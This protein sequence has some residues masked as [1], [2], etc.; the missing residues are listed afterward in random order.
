MKSI[1][2]ILLGIL[3]IPFHISAQTPEKNDP[4][5]QTILDKL[6]KATKSYNSIKATFTF[7]LENKKENNSESQDGGLLLKGNKYKLEIAG[8]E[9]ICNGS[10]LWTYIKDAEEVQINEPE[11]EEGSI[12][13]ANIF[14][15]YESGFK[16]RFHSEEEYEG[17][18]CQIVN[19]Y[20][21]DANEKPY[22][23]IRLFIDK[24]KNQL[25]SIKIMGKEGDNYYYTINS[26]A[27][28]LELTDADFEFDPS[29]HPN[30]EVVDL[31]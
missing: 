6:S 27:T 19:L 7:T 30:V 14:T 8:Q 31:R 16:F 3:I 18:T 25:A 24:A 23:T 29:K 9:I 17:R 21:I 5:A 15:V 13:P 1:K 10:T 4:V 20:P 26:F 12:S 2:R 28:D 22:H 11:Y